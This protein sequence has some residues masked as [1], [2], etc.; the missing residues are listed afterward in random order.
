[1]EVSP[2]S[3]PTAFANTVRAYEN[4]PADFRRTLDGLHC[5]NTFNLTAALQDEEPSRYRMADHPE[6]AEGIQLKTAVHPAVI[7]VPHT[8]RKAIFV[9]EFNA[10][11]EPTRARP[12]GPFCRA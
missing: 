1:M 9:S 4:L 10:S 8:G 2:T 6:P 12:R 11:P 5:F 3:S 7:T